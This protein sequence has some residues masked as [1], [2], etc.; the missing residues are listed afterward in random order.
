MIRVESHFHRNGSQ[1][2][3]GELPKPVG[4]VVILCLTFTIQPL[5][6]GSVWGSLRHTN[7]NR[8]GRTFDIQSDS[9]STTTDP[10]SRDMPGLG[11]KSTSYCL[12]IKKSH[13]PH[14]SVYFEY[15]NHI[16]YPVEKT[17][18]TY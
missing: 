14:I 15:V 4:P 3:T 2:T 7:I 6:H 1:L 12:T 10:Y 11:L 13:V 16:R 9:N 5:R 17:A 8:T 18:V